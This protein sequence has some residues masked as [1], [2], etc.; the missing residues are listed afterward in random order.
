MYERDKNTIFPALFQADYR[1]PQ[2]YGSTAPRSGESGGFIA[3]SLDFEGI[4]FY[5]PS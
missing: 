2:D 3:E 4:N 5:I 1:R